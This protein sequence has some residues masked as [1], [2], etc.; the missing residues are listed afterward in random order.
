MLK[1]VIFDMDGILVD[2]E[3]QHL[4]AM[5]QAASAFDIVLTEDYCKKFIGC[6][7]Q[8][9]LSMLTS[10]YPELDAARF[11]DLFH[12]KKLE[13]KAEEGLIPIEGSLSLLRSLPSHQIKAAIASSSTPD[14][15]Q[16]VVDTLGLNEYID[17]IV[18]GSM[19]AHSKPEPDIFLLA[20]KELGVTIEECIILEDSMNGSIA[21]KRA[22]IP[23]I[24]YQN[25]NSGNQNLS[26]CCCV[27]EDITALDYEGVLEE[28]NRYHGYPVTILTTDRLIIREFSVE[29]VDALHAL[30][31]AEGMTDYIP[32]LSS[33]EE[34][35]EKMASYIKGQYH[36]YRFGLWGIFLK[37]TN[38]LIGCSG[39]QCVDLFEDAEADIELAYLTGRDHQQKGYAL[40][41]TTAILNYIKDYYDF[42]SL[43]ALIHPENTASLHLIDTLGFSYEQMTEHKGITCRLYRLPLL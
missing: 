38:E 39:I 41:Y 14:E 29:D 20:A 21:A 4:R 30:Y 19:V 33:L 10:D 1:A 22:Q 7:M 23:C 11:T 8:D 6:N 26:E 13:V 17:V 34:E 32:A 36:F 5:I 15:I 25:K 3:P 9:T 35:K 31:Q 37:D 12:Q 27:Y 24:G 43:I 16:L 18:S 2:T 40:E 42:P 28:Y